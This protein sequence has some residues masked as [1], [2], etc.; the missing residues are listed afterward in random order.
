MNVAGSVVAVLC[1]AD[2]FW[3]YLHAA[4]DRACSYQLW[5]PLEQGLSGPLK[6][7]RVL[8]YSDQSG[9]SLKTLGLKLG[10]VGAEMRNCANCYAASRGFALSNM[11]LFCRQCIKNTS[12]VNCL[13]GE[14][15]K[16]DET[17]WCSSSAEFLNFLP[18]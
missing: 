7:L 12:L 6:C 18:L 8:I 3:Q 14:N 15:L 2:V 16:R 1:C 4:P 13:Q 17:L 5:A 11:L 10:L 9:F